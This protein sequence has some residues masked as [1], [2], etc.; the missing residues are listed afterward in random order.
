MENTTL[1]FT[2]FPDY[3]TVLF[4]S[5]ATVTLAAT[6]MLAQWLCSYNSGLIG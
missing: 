4:A 5:T 2:E 1:S 3:F 6:L